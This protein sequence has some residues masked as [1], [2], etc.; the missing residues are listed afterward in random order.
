MEIF[1]NKGGI[2]ICRKCPFICRLKAFLK[3]GMVQIFV[4]SSDKPDRQQAHLYI[5]MESFRD[6]I[7]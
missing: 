6:L 2:S 4:N 1:A 3:F 5:S 7:I